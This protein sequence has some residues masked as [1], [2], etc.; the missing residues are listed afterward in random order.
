[1]SK[2]FSWSQGGLAAEAT[3]SNHTTQ[4]LIVKY[5]VRKL[6]FHSVEHKR[7]VPGSHHN[8]IPID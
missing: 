1:M 3:T 8:K 2:H 6:L 4:C 7:L 5:L